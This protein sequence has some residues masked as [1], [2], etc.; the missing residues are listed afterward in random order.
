M[1]PCSFI[2]NSTCYYMMWE[3]IWC[4]V[5]NDTSKT[6]AALVKMTQYK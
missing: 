6:I 4:L 2:I 3:V 5:K 1:I